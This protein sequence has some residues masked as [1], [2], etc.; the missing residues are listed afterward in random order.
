MPNNSAHR[1]SRKNPAYSTDK[2]RQTIATLKQ[3]AYN[4]YQPAESYDKALTFVRASGL[5]PVIIAKAGCYSTNKKIRLFTVVCKER[6]GLSYW[7]VTLEG[8]TNLSL[9][10][11]DKTK[12]PEFYIIRSA[13][14]TLATLLTKTK[15][16]DPVVLPGVL[17]RKLTN[18][19]LDECTDTNGN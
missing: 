1:K 10:K 3:D 17:Y 6:N 2:A 12:T 18:L 15:I 14:E 4:P 7:T 8:K 13:Y 16:S 19:S 9:K 11:L 5:V